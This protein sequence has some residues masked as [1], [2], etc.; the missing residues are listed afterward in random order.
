MPVVLVVDDSQ[1]DQRRVG[2]LLPKD[3]DWL[4]EY[5]DNGR[6]A[7]DA[8]ALSVPDVVI[9]DMM[10]PEMDGI[11]LVNRIRVDFP[12]VPVILITAHGS[13]QLAVEALEQGA[14]SYVPKDQ[15]QTKLRETVE[16][17]LA[18]AHADRTYS[19]LIECL[20]R[21]QYHFTLDND[22]TLI[23]PLVDLVQQ[24]LAGMRCCNASGRMHAG[25]AL[26]EALLNAMLHGNLEMDTQQVCDA[27]GQ[28]RQGHRS[29][30]VEQ[31]RIEP[32]YCKR[33]I[34]AHVDIAPRQAIFTVRDEGRGFDTALVPEAHDPLAVNRPNGRGLVLIKNFME[35]VRFSATGNE[36]TMTMRCAGDRCL[37]EGSA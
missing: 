8:M 12:E 7:I 24:M 34:H 4:V 19:R 15:M 10:M 13:E 9:T 17:V 14:T 20:A 2:G 36:V 29:E 30:F 23:P 37:D 26:E 21:T 31:R 25:I 27:R 5:A 18:L 28:L 32:P 33:L 16:Q 22:P 11:E 3:L 1:V 6:E 35:D